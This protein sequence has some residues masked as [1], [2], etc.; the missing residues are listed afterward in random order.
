MLYRLAPQ[1]LAPYRHLTALGM[2]RRAARARF[3]AL[4]RAAERYLAEG[5]DPRS[6]SPERVQ[7]LG[8]LPLDWFGGA[9]FSAFSPFFNCRVVL[10]PA[11]PTG[12]AVGVE[13]SYDVLQPIFETYGADAGQIFFP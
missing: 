4:L 1:T 5:G 3:E 12:I 9:V 10:G 11:K 6:L 2:Q 7:Q 8:L 13:G